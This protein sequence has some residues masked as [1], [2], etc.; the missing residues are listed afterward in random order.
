MYATRQATLKVA[1]T[2][3]INQDMWEGTLEQ[4]SFSPVPSYR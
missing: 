1:T 2:A 4:N 3:I